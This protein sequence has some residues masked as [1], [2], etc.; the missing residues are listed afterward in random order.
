MSIDSTSSG[1]LLIVDDEAVAVENLAHAFRKSGY[2]VTTRTTGPGGIEALENNRFDVVLTDLRMEHIDGMAIL[3]RALELDPDTAVVLI[4]GHA[5]LDSAVTAMRAGAYHYIAKPFRLDDVRKVIANAM[6]RAQLR[7][8]NRRLRNQV[9]D[10]RS[11]VRIITQD[12]AMQRLLETAQQIAPTDCNVLITGES[13]TGKE[14]L[15]RYIHLHSGRADKPFIAVNC[16]ALQEELLANELFGHEKGAFT[17]A[18][19]KR[20]GLIEAADGGTLFLD[21]IGDMSLA[22][23]IKLLRVLQER[24]VLHLGSTQPIPV[25]VRFLAATNRDLRSE[26]DTGGFRHDLY[27]RLDVVTLQLPPLAE[28]RD[29]IPLL[30]YYFLKKVAHRM[31]RTVVDIEPEAMAMLRDYDYPG[32]VRELENVVERGVALATGRK[33]TP[34]QL[35]PA[36]VDRAVHVVRATGENLPTLEDRETEYI[37]WV[38][39]RTGGNRTRAA[40][41][42]GIDRVSLWRKLKNLESGD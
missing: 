25:D 35:P 33:L 41:I 18:A 40:E 23:Q 10:N 29:D 24:E 32:N 21:E 1:K 15:A 19:E 39:N 34:A 20:S 17:G 36:L 4:T 3:N 38:L 14:L 27:F 30:A 42:L 7:R 12:A 16:G 5:S 8:E 26:V 37:R 6:E 13:G 2:T 31:G 11:G 28:R 9:H 22:M